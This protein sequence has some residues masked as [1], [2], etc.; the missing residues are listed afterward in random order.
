MVE[1]IS[2]WAEGIIIAVIIATIIEMILPESNNKKYIKMVIGVYI[3]FTIVSP[4]ITKITNKEFDLDTQTYDKYFNENVYQTSANTLTQKNDEN[5]ESVF[6][7]NMKADIKQRLK[8]KGYLVSQIDMDVELEDEKNYGR[9]KKIEI[10]IQ[11]NE[12]EDKNETEDKIAKVNTIQI[13]NTSSQDNTIQQ[14]T[15]R[16]L[17]KEETK[18][19]KTYLNSVYEIDKKNINIIG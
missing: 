7:S 18:D 14:E 16:V 13:G 4:I 15:K 11:K 9:I 19:I 8:E 1:W 6:L 12:E 3:L 10:S 5:V 2:N 17:T